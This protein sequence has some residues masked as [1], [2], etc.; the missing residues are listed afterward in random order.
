MKWSEKQSGM[1]KRKKGLIRLLG[2]LL[3]AAMLPVSAAEQK[4]SEQTFYHVGDVVFQTVFEGYI[5]GVPE[6]F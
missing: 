1:K 6:G 5:G 4:I 2:T 3:I